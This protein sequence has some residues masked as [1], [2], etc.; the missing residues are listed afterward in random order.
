MKKTKDNIIDENTIDLSDVSRATSGTIANA[1][2][3]GYKIQVVWNVNSQNVGNNSSNVTFKVQLCSTGSQYTIISSATKNGSLTINGTT[4]G[5]TFNAGLS[6]NQTKT[7]FTKTV[8][9]SHNSDGSKTC[10]ISTTLG[11]NVTLSGTYWGNVSASGNA[12]LNAIPRTSSFSLNTTSGT[13]GS[14]QFVVTIN[15]ASSSFTHKVYYRFG[16]LNW[17]GSSN[18]TTSFSFTPSIND[19]SQIPSS[20]SGVATIVVETWNGSTHIGTASQNITLHVPDSVKPSFSSLGTQLIEAGASSSFGY[21]KGK[22]KCKLTIN[23]ASGNQGS[24]IT[25]YHIS[26]AG[27]SSGA[28]P[29]TTGVLATAGNVVFSAYVVDSRGRKSDTKTVTIN[30]K[31]YTSPIIDIASA[32]RCNSEGGLDEN[33][34]YIKVH[35][36]DIISQITGN[37]YSNKIEFKPSSSS[38]WTN[39]GSYASARGMI[40]GNGG[41]STTSTYN[42]RFTVS[43]SFETVTKVVDVAPAFVTIDFKRGG[44]GIAIGKPSEKDNLFEVSMDFNASSDSLKLGK[45]IYGTNDDGIG[46]KADSLSLSSSNLVWL[47]AN[48]YYDGT[49]DKQYRNDLGSSQLVVRGNE[50]PKFRW[51]SGKDSNGDL[52][53]TPYYDILTTHQPQ[54]N[55]VTV[56]TSNTWHSNGWGASFLTTGNGDNATWDTHNVIFKTHWG[57]GIRDYRDVCSIV[58]DAR[59]GTMHLKGNVHVKDGQRVMSHYHDGDFWKMTAD[60]DSV[61]WIKTT[62][63]GIIPAWSD[64]HNG[65]SNLGTTSYPFREGCFRYISSPSGGNLD[66]QFHSGTGYLNVYSGSGAGIVIGRPWS[67]SSGTE[68]ALHNNKGNG[69]GFIGNS[70]TSFYRVYGAGGSVSDRNKKYHITKALSEEQYENIKNLNIYNYRTISTSDTSSTELAEKHLT[71]NGFKD[72]DGN[73]IST[74]VVVEGIEYK[75]LEEG[76]TQDEIK[77]LRIKEIVEKNPHFSEV[78]RQ[79]LMLGAMVDELPTEVTFYDNEGGDGK[80]VDMY[81]YTTMIAGASKHLIEKVENLEKENDLKDKRI[82]ELESRLEKMEELLNGI[83]NKG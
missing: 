9:I 67:G 17:L 55:N 24:W 4:Y 59:T 50:Y 1:F 2:R 3:T 52:S 14:T 63:N 83:I 34:T 45:K 53:W 37:A 44:K 35:L 23:G 70:G 27:F 19:C 22:S 18:A 60:G 81:S 56:G 77:E 54:L 25:S 31:D 66:L 79:D 20:T 61:T 6:A 43:D 39:A 42:V 58:I 82:D 69:W 68:P 49:G 78:K 40:I 12:S 7:V 74:S 32:Y 21:V 47:K 28:T 51:N 26:G 16:N 8:D 57:I 29:F 5:F 11:I 75:E 10:A 72:K 76:L 65:I 62:Q 13:I 48:N 33:G 15:R 64:I 71:H 80:A 36:E 38:T 73:Y 30:V 41:I 46:S